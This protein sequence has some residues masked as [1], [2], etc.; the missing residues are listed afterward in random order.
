[1][2]IL[3]G[4]A[5]DQIAQ[6]GLSSL[7]VIYYSAQLFRLLSFMFAVVTTWVLNRNFTFDATRYKNKSLWLEFIHYLSLMSIGGIIN[8]VT[9]SSSVMASVYIGERPI[10]GVAIGSVAGMSFNFLS[11]KIFIYIDKDK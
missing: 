5:I 2:V 8:I 3:V 9:Y 10:I 7:S 11:S 1:M 6:S 4:L